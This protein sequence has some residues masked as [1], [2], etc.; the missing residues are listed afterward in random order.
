MTSLREAVGDLIAHVRT[1]APDAE[2]DGRLP[3]ETIARLKT[4]GVFRAFVP[5][6]HG[7]DERSLLDVLDAMTD[8]GVGCASTAWVGTL[9]AIHNVAVCWLE[10]EGQEEI[11]RNGPDVVVASS[12]AP[13]GT[14]EAAPGGFRLAGRWG[15]SS[16]VDHAE[17]IMLGANLKTEDRGALVEYFLC[18]VHSS[19]IVRLDD[20]NVSGLRA[21]G[22]KS[23]EL[24]DVFVPNHRALLLRTVREGTAPGLAL[25]ARPFYRLP[26]DA[27]FRSAFP[28]A[29]LGTAIAMLEEFR[30]Y[31]ASRVNVFSG[32]GFRGNSGSA[33]RLAEAAAQIDAARL[34]YRRELATLDRCAQEGTPLPP[35]A[36]ERI[37]YSTPFVVDIC[38]RAVLQLF[39]GSGGRAIRD[40]NPLQRYFRD[41]HA[42]TQH[43]AMDMDGAGETY[44]RALLRNPTF[45]LGARE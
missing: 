4:L 26:W 29:A 14:L 21:T 37:A 35:G 22:S 34:V 18:F 24:S 43:A 8:V 42:M 12:V 28:P 36:A 27:L 10:R 32:A 30:D 3:A 19:E 41:I 5:R 6:I 7:G 15:F 39:R 13:T 33:V 11:F 2:K 20:W 23:V 17:W 40:S 38:S 31:T 16:G 25:H 44:G 9:A 1:C 45:C